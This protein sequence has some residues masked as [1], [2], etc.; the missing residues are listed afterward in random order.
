MKRHSLIAVAIL[1]FAL[2]P[3]A[4]A[5][6]VGLV[7]PPVDH[8]VLDPVG[9]KPSNWRPNLGAWGEGLADQ[10]LRLR[11]YE[12]HSIGNRGIDRIAVKRAADGS[13]KEVRIVEVK[14]NDSAKPQLG[15]TKYNGRQMSRKWLAENLKKMRRSND[16][17][18]KK[19]ASEISRFSKASGRSL[20]SLGE[21]WH[22]NPQTG[23][24]TL[25]TA[26]AKTVKALF[27]M[28][29]LLTNIQRKARSQS[30]RDWATL[31]L[32]KLDQIKAARM[33]E[34]SGQLSVS[35]ASRRAAKRVL[36]RLAGPIAL[37]AAVAIDVKQIADVEMAYRHGQISIRHRNMSHLRA[38]GGIAGAFAG[39]KI[40]AV[41]GVWAGAFGGPFAE[42]TIPAGGIVGA[43][44]G[45][46][47]GYFA[48]S[49]VA[50]YAATQ[51]YGSI[52][53]S[54]RE[55]FEIEWVSRP[56]PGDSTVSAK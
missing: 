35:S 14:T 1:L 20:T 28:E 24:V 18:I 23:K 17:R 8:P 52:D 47:G 29:R 39:F 46:V 12:V 33:A 51:W 53:S 56:V 41:A 40:G 16:P 11:G 6:P 44:I 34:S 2:R 31:H 30:V 9:V 13:L 7:S 19:L 43:A 48:G 45:G 27:S 38:A 55:R 21:V 50:G 36:A 4:L 3:I 25:Y 26:D 15:K 54:V 10:T 22:I 37:I 49:A 32:A 42:I 5:A